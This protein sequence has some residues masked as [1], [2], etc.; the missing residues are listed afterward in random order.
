MNLGHSM[1]NYAQF[2]Q[3]IGQ[4]QEVLS[5]TDP[6]FLADLQ[7]KQQR[8]ALNNAMVARIGDSIRN[9]P[10]ASRNVRI[11]QGL[12]QGI[13]MAMAMKNMN[14]IADAKKKDAEARNAAAKYQGDY[15]T[16]ELDK[17]MNPIFREGSAE[18]IA[19]ANRGYGLIEQYQ[20][21]GLENNPYVQQ[22]INGQLTNKIQRAMAES[23]AAKHR[24]DSREDTDSIVNKRAEL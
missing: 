23:E 24:Q 2:F 14:E 10:I 7:A 13:Y 8:M 20:R 21:Q 19:N 12:L 17:Q 9:T 15:L 3:P 16:T 1:S 6:A 18:D 11:G 4:G 22:F 5:G